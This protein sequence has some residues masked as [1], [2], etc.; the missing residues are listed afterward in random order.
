MPNGEP[1]NRPTAD[2]L[3]AVGQAQHEALLVVR[4]LRPARAGV[5]GVKGVEG[6]D[7]VEDRGQVWPT[8]TTL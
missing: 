3:A 7:G 6:A 2:P 1:L 5:E 4:I 8:F